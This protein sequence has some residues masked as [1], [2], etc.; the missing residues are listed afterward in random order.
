MNTFTSQEVLT[1]INKM[2]FFKVVHTNI[3]DALGTNIHKLQ[4]REKANFFKFLA[5]SLFGE[6]EHVDIPTRITV[7]GKEYKFNE[8]TRLTFSH[9]MDELAAYGL[10]EKGLE[11]GKG[12]PVVYHTCFHHT[13]K[14]KSTYKNLR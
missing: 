11:Q 7:N 12:S 2:D 13:E 1:K 9:L 5:T 8:F 6:I 10:V 3:N 4:S 14:G